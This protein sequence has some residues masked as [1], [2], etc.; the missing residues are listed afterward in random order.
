VLGAFAIDIHAGEFFAV[1]IVDGDLP[2][3]VLSPTVFLELGRIPCL[4]LRHDDMAPIGMRGTIA[5]SC[6]SRK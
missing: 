1:M 4:L 5:I 2:M 3:A 6:P